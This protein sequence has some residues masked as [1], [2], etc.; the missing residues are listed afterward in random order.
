MKNIQLDEI[1]VSE[2]NALKS[3]IL[4]SKEITVQILNSI[5][6]FLYLVIDTHKLS[7]NLF[8]KIDTPEEIWKYVNTN[9][10]YLLLEKYFSMSF[11]DTEKTRYKFFTYKEFSMEMHSVI[12]RNK[13]TSF[14]E[15]FW[16]TV[17]DC[18]G[19]FY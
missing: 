15:Y 8:Q 19:P 2:A 16:Q 13:K 1:I 18:F 11:T 14:L 3:E 12:K 7:S 17:F 10:L 5:K 6:T 9:K 4:R